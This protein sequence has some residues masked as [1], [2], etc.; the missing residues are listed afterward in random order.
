MYSAF[1]LMKLMV[2][3][4][5]IQ[6]F[7]INTVQ[8]SVLFFPP[9]VSSQE[10]TLV[11]IGN[12]KIRVEVFVFSS[13]LLLGHLV[14]YSATFLEHSS[15]SRFYCM[16]IL[17]IW[18]VLFSKQSLIAFSFSLIKLCCFIFLR[19]NFTEE[20]NG[21]VVQNPVILWL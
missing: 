1:S 18:L 13:F 7:E 4:Q 17:Y 11:H 19:H 15:Q 5:K 6:T 16:L 12:S 8:K 3:N 21:N 14:N 10:H 20:K 2:E 9:Y